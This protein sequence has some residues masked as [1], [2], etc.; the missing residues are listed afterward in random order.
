[1]TPT[2]TI[3]TAITPPTIP[4]A[5]TASRETRVDQEDHVP[6]ELEAAAAEGEGEEDGMEMDMEGMVV[7]AVVLVVEWADKEVMV[8]KEVMDILPMVRMVLTVL[9]VGVQ[10]TLQMLRTMDTPVVEVVA[11]E[12]VA[13][14]V[15]AHITTRCS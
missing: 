13:E 3:A 1:M 6:T 12:V 15:V 2:I 8:G 11:V 4:Q 5:L 14:E 7:T 9:I 10:Q